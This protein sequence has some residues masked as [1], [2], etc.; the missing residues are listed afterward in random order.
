MYHPLFDCYVGGF[1]YFRVSISRVCYE[2]VF[3]IQ[4]KY[5]LVLYLHEIFSSF[6]KK[7]KTRNLEGLTRFKHGFYTQDWVVSKGRYET[8]DG[9]ILI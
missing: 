2:V 3:Q 5:C 9:G 6:V 8:D 4:I 7:V 1:R